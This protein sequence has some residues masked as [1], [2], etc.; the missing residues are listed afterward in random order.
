MQINK[1]IINI[2]L[3]DLVTQSENLRANLNAIAGAIQDCEYWLSE[4]EKE[5]VTDGSTATN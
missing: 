5:E 1:D 2:R 3:K 4:L